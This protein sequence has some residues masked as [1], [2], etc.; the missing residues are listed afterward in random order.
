MWAVEIY[1]RSKLAHTPPPAHRACLLTVLS[2]HAPSIAMEEEIAA[3][4]IDSGF[5]M[6]KAGFAGNDAL[7]AMFPSMVLGAPDTRASW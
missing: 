1:L 2:P 4:V 3:L 5:G 6:C 7:R